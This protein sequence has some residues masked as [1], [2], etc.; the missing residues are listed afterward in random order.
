MPDNDALCR[1]DD[2][3][4]EE[5]LTSHEPDYFEGHADYSDQGQSV[6]PSQSQLSLNSSN[7]LMGGLDLATSIPS[8]E[9]IVQIGLDFALSASSVTLGIENSALD[10]VDK[11]KPVFDLLK[12][13]EEIIADTDKKIARLGEKISDVKY[14]EFAKA[15]NKSVSLPLDMDERQREKMLKEI[16]EEAEIKIKRKAEAIKLKVVELEDVVAKENIK[17]GSLT[18]LQNSGII[19]SIEEV[20]GYIEEF[21]KNFSR[22]VTTGAMGIYNGLK[23]VT[24]VLIEKISNNLSKF[25]PHAKLSAPDPKASEAKAAPVKNSVTKTKSVNM[26]KLKPKVDK[27]LK[28]A[29]AIPD[30]NVVKWIGKKLP[31]IDA[32]IILASIGNAMLKDAETGGYPYENT[33]S[34]VFEEIGGWVGGK[35]S[36][37]TLGMIGTAIAPG[38]GTAIGTTIGT[39]LG[40][41]AGEGCSNWAKDVCDRRGSGKQ[42]REAIASFIDDTSPTSDDE[43]TVERDI[44]KL[45]DALVAAMD[46]VWSEILEVY[47]APV[48]IVVGDV[49][50][51]HGQAVMQGDYYIFGHKAM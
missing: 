25:I 2:V 5:T 40:S 49:L 27:L 11:T 18:K 47:I 50:K 12:D 39:I 8:R 51:A 36:G 21:N 31:G 6:M 28:Y 48:I 7:L 17:R 46:D 16:V 34:T 15:V 13:I 9:K 33:I 22:I 45:H 26:T 20:K 14:E 1:I 3:H 44:Y 41:V 4:D 43:S 32:S 24:I 37:L 38:A 42:V 30:L 10:I 19:K 35:L 29:K 23:K